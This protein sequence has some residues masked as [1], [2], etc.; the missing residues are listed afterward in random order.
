MYRNRYLNGA[1][2]VIAVLLLLILGTITH[3]NGPASTL[4]NQAYAQ[5][6]ASESNWLFFPVGNQQVRRLVILDKNTN[7]VYDYDS[8]GALENTWVISTPGEQINKR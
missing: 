1:L 3:Q 2:T 6:P 5:S 8:S 4:P 7:T